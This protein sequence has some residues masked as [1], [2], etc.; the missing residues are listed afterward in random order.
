MWTFNKKKSRILAGFLA[1]VL[2]LSN[3]AANVQTVYASGSTF[4]LGDSGEWES[5]GN[6]ESDS[7]G[8]LLDDM[9]SGETAYDEEEYDFYVSIWPE[10]KKNEDEDGEEAEED[11]DA[12]EADAPEIWTGKWLQYMYDGQETD[13]TLGQELLMSGKYEKEYGPLDMD[14]SGTWEGDNDEVMEVYPDGTALVKDEGIVN[15]TFTYDGEAMTAAPEEDAPAEETE[16]AAHSEEETA[17]GEEENMAGDGQTFGDPQTADDEPTAGGET[18]ETVTTAAEETETEAESEAETETETEAETTADAEVSTAAPENEEETEPAVVKETEAEAT[19]SSTEAVSEESTDETESVPEATGSNA[20]QPET[21]ESSE[22]DTDPGEDAGT[23]LEPGTVLTWVVCVKYS[24]PALIT[25]TG[26]SFESSAGEMTYYEQ[27]TEA[28]VSGSG[29]LTVSGEWK[30]NVVISG[31]NVTIEGNG[32]IDASGRK[33]SVILIDNNANVTL[34]GNVTIT[35][36]EG[37]WVTND[38]MEPRGN[39]RFRVGGGVYVYEG[40]FTLKDGTISGNTAQRG[41]GI[42]VNNIIEKNADDTIKTET[43]S[44][45]TMT[46]GIVEEN[47]TVDGDAGYWYAGEGG[48]IFV[49]GRAT[50]SG[51]V[52]RN[53]TCNSQTDLGGGGLYIN[54]SGLATLINAT[55]TDNTAAGFGGGIAGCCHG[56]MSLVATDGVALYGNHANGTNHANANGEKTANVREIVDHWNASTAQG[57]SAEN[58]KDF[59]TA[60]SSII[61]NYM[62]GGGSANY[63]AKFGSE[64]V[65]TVSDDE[66]ITK[67]NTNVGLVAHPSAESIA[68]VPA[69]VLIT[70]NSSTVH[71]GGI[72][73]NGG[74]YFGSGRDTEVV[75]NVFSMELDAAKSLKEG[76]TDLSLEKDAYIF[77]LYSGSDCKNVVATA[78]NDA[79]GNIKFSFNYF[80][81]ISQYV[82]DDRVTFYLKEEPGNDPNIKYDDSVYQIDL[83][84]TVTSDVTHTETLDHT[85]KNNH[86]EEITVTYI[87]NTYS[88]KKKTITKVGGSNVEK[89]TFINRK[90]KPV[91]AQP[92]V[93]KVIALGNQDNIPAEKTFNFTMTVDPAAANQFEDKSVTKSDGTEVNANYTKTGSVTID[94]DGTFKVINFE[95]LQF[96][97]A[98]TYVFLINETVPNAYDGYV[99]DE[100]VWR[101]TVKVEGERGTV[102]TKTEEYEKLGK[103][104]SVIVAADKATFTNTYSARYLALPL[105]VHKELTGVVSGYKASEVSFTFNMSVDSAAFERGDLD[106]FSAR[107]FKSNEP[108]TSATLRFVDGKPSPSSTQGTAKLGYVRFKKPGT[109]TITV[110]ETQGNEPG[111]VYDGGIWNIRITVIDD[112]NGQ[113]KISELRYTKNQGDE[114]KDGPAYD[115]NGYTVIEPGDPLSTGDDEYDRYGYSQLDDALEVSFENEYAP[116]RTSYTPMVTKVIEGSVTALDKEFTFNLEEVQAE[117]GRFAAGKVIG[118]AKLTLKAGETNDTDDPVY[119]CFDTIE[120]TRAGTYKYLIKEVKPENAAEAYRG[121]TFDDSVWTLVV[122]VQDYDG[123]LKVASA[124]YTPENG[125]TSQEAATFTNNYKVTPTEYAPR[126]NKVIAGDRLPDA[127]SNTEFRF[128]I[129]QMEDYPDVVMPDN[130]QTTVNGAALADFDPIEFNAAGTYEFTVKEMP[131]EEELGFTYDTTVWNL[132]VT[133]TDKDGNLVVTGV[134]YEKDASGDEPDNGYSDVTWELLE[135]GGEDQA[136]NIYATFVNTFE[137]EDAKAT[138]KVRKV[139]ETLTSDGEPSNVEAPTGKVFNFHL[140]NRGSLDGVEVSSWTAS[141]TGSGEAEFGEMTFSKVGRFVFAIYEDAGDA[142]G[143]DYD[144]GS[145]TVEINVV[146]VNGRLMIGYLDENG[147]LIEEGPVYAHAVVGELDANGKLVR[148][149]VVDPETNGEA[150]TFTN[151]YQVEAAHYAPGVKKTVLGNPLEEEQFNFTLESGEGNDADGFAF[152]EGDSGRHVTVNGAGTGNFGGITFKKA[153]T[154]TFKIKETSSNSPFWADDDRTWTLTVV[155]EDQDSQLVVTSH[156]YVRDGED[157]VTS[158]T[159][160]EFENE[161]HGPGDLSISKTVSGN[162]GERTRAFNFTVTFTNLKGEPLAGTYEYTGS[163]TVE[164]VEAPADGS[165][166]GGVLNIT[167]AHG[168]KITI[169]GI[170]ADTRYTVTEAEADTESYQTSVEVDGNS[171]TDDE[172]AGTVTRDAETVVEYLNY[173]NRSGG[174]TP[175]GPGPGPSPEFELI[176]DEPTP[177]GSFENLENIEDEDVPLAFLA[178]MTGDDKPVGAAALFGLVALGMMGAFGI[179]AFKKDEDDA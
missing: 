116:E 157:S 66:V 19:E 31:G 28:V 72:G 111:Y 61:S 8:D 162:R 6:Q 69:G 143:Y 126:I 115:I 134:K 30:G 32:T 113:L 141:V 90:T 118:S 11:P 65:Y 119:A 33:T 21:S 105:Q 106:V 176:T 170:P 137:T 96:N 177:L 1:M 155:V 64:T 60:G 59:Y 160:A 112:G 47:K 4:R 54:N 153:G 146:D 171:L 76:D 94:K 84:L 149:E 104:G 36:G 50:I 110:K 97:R 138:L 139:I 133:V 45:F 144:P 154:Y 38:E 172:A 101:W 46:G 121:Y 24:G 86:F 151:R 73:C 5:A 175:G 109:Y 120:Y 148:T 132:T 25:N 68:K 158:D 80:E 15:V 156:T 107:N 78:K 125:V 142:A 174:T 103:D 145:W 98:G 2:V 63:K 22:T 13:H 179:M 129:A 42:F 161:Y 83:E 93:E 163:S 27:N 123:K 7:S 164:G 159:E 39:Y 136:P 58:T 87:E 102:L 41:G 173:R 130:T 37:T 108:R 70:G 127:L 152:A 29:T 20:L 88:V 140:E 91:T 62:A 40:S 100:S 71:G 53:N 92:N 89:L 23:T 16:T 18:A 57:L 49:F 117:S 3:I 75:I 26:L 56:E 131:G 52:I 35:G 147:N 34:D 77:N 67:E 150:A 124:T 99:Y 128:E 55:I 82:K 51:G 114:S 48:G 17:S 178:P 95:E 168:Q 135:E 12:E 79:D 74:L 167:L 85:T 9:G 14:L 10:M 169:K 122:N 44:Y 43:P 165:F 166:S 81:S